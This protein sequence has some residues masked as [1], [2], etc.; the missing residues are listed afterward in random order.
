MFKY[1]GS[2]MDNCRNNSIFEKEK[3]KRNLQIIIKQKKKMNGTNKSYNNLA[4]KPKCLIERYKNII[5]IKYDNKSKYVIYKN[6]C[7]IFKSFLK[8]LQIINNR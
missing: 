5:H 4:F 2:E 7:F 8:T 1:K 3:E 6:S